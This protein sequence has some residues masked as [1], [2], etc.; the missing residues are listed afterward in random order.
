MIES[1]RHQQIVSIREAQPSDA[2]AVARLADSIDLALVDDPED[3]GFLAANYT[4]TDYKKFIETANFAFILEAEEEVRV[5][6][7]DLVEHKRKELV[8]FLVAYGSELVDA[9]DEFN[10]HVKEQICEKFVT[11]SSS[12]FLVPQGTIPK[13]TLWKLHV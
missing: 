13:K 7:E 2:K 5:S 9:K 3:K 6:S 8:G 11:A 12:N 1:S 4:E 10:T